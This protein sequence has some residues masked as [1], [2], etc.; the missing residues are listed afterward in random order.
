MFGASVLTLKQKKMH[1]LLPGVGP[2]VCKLASAFYSLSYSP[3]RIEVR[4]DPCLDDGRRL[5]C[6]WLGSNL[7]P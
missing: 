1:I 2:I 3:D 5:E 6:K 7:G 4:E